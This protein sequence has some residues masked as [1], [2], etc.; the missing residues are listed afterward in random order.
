MAG[1]HLPVEVGAGIEADVCRD[2]RR[3]GVVVAGKA[4]DGDSLALQFT[5]RADAV[6]SEKLEAPGVNAP[7]NY[8]RGASVDPQ[9]WHGE[10]HQTQVDLARGEA[11]DG[12]TRAI[13][14][15]VLHSG[16]AF[17]RG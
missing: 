9:N 12:G 2:H 6:A 3:E 15:H 14:S 7:K 1:M 10:R 13:D 5:D 17:G 11:L 16:K 8:E 4:R